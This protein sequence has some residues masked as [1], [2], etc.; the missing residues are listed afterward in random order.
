MSYKCAVFPDR[1]MSEEGDGAD[2]RGCSCFETTG[3]GLAGVSRKKQLQT[4]I[5][6][7]PPDFALPLNR[8][9]QDEIIS[10]HIKNIL[11]S[12]IRLVSCNEAFSVKM[13]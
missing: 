8:N 1:E 11:L 4:S 7:G 9:W 3:L 10:S 6:S 2:N 13:H 12:C 5:S